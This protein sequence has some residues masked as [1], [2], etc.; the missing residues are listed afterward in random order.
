MEAEYKK[1]CTTKWQERVYESYLKNGFNIADVAKELDCTKNSIYKIIRRINS[2]VPE[3]T[4]DKSIKSESILYNGS[5]DI[6]QRWVKTDKKSESI[7]LFKEYCKVYS[8][9]LPKYKPTTH[10]KSNKYEDNLIVYPIADLH[11]G[12]LS[13]SPET[14]NNYSTKSASDMALKYVQK[15]IN[16]SP[17]CNECLICN[18]GDFLHVDNQVNR[19]ERSGNVLDVDGRYAK[20]LNIGI[21]LMRY[22]IEYALLKHKHVSIVNCIGN[23]DDLGSLWL[24]AALSNIY[25]NENRLTIL[26]SPCQRHYYKFGNTLIG[27]THGSD[28]K[29]KNLPLIMASEKP[30]EWGDT[31]FHY[32]YTGHWHQDSVFED[33]SCK[34]ETFRALCAKDAW[35]VSKGYL[36]GRDIKGIIIDKDNGETERITL[37]IK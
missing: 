21:K 3:N 24:S 37:N 9:K 29:I 23:H 36:S 26:N 27:M 25:E 11:L 5:G 10:K 6:I 20:I 14:G 1:Y 32:F 12:M 34:V 16:R 35:A 17:A 31:K 13:W 22:T 28:V 7:D 30:Q 8:R 18:L 33:G 19:T 4:S 2:H 15:L